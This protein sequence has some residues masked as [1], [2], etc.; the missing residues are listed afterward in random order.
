[1]YLQTERERERGMGKGEGKTSCC[2]DE[3][4]FAFVK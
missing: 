3:N 2:E 4:I 1:M